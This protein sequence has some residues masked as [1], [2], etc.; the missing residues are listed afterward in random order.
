MLLSMTG[1]VLA[2]NADAIGLLCSKDSHSPHLSPAT[3]APDPHEAGHD[4]GKPFLPSERDRVNVSQSCS[5]AQ[6]AYQ[7]IVITALPAAGH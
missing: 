7:D 6:E 2:W 1:T 4:L 3:F 5:A